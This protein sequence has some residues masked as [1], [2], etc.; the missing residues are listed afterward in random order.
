MKEKVGDVGYS[1]LY[2]EVKYPSVRPLS[3]INPTARMEVGTSR[4]VNTGEK[5]WFSG[6]TILLFCNIGECVVAGTDLA[7]I[8]CA[9]ESVDGSSRKDGE[10]TSEK[11][12]NHSVRTSV[13]QL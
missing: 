8:Y 6:W 2:L 5:K 1:E 4:G 9:E 7:L 12:T 11:R 10:R 3:S 13:P